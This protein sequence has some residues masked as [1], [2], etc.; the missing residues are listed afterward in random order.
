MKS[1]LTRAFTIIVFTCLIGAFVAFKSGAF[2][3]EEDATSILKK[4]SKN[5]SFTSH[6]NTPEVKTMRFDNLA[7]AK[8]QEEVIMS[9][10]KSA[11]ILDKRSINPDAERFFKDTTKH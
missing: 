8:R 11:I 5:S 1:S 4:T 3:E 9:S 6:A 10:S 7:K 2:A